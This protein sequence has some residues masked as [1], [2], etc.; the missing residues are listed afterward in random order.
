MRADTMN[1]ASPIKILVI[2]DDPDGRRSVTEA[3][4]DAGYSVIAVE[5]GAEGVSRFAAEKF[6][7]VLTDVKLPDIDGHEVLVRIRNQ[8]QDRKS[9][10]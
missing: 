1:I 5:T 3:L 6:D 7:A 10:V 9:V 4:A 2:E 8:D